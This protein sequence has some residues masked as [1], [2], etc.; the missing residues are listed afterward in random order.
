MSSINLMLCIAFS[1]C[2]IVSPAFAGEPTPEVRKI[3][4]AKTQAY[5]DALLKC[6]ATAMAKL[7]SPEVVYTS[8]AA[9]VADRA[10]VLKDVSAPK[11]PLGVAELKVNTMRQYGDTVVAN[12]DANFQH[13]DGQV[14]PH[15]TVTI[16][17]VKQGHDWLMVARQATG[18]NHH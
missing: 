4:L 6:D 7:L 17:W 15:G 12:Y 9:T 18:K 5:L 1:V 13:K 14:I 8:A 3:V 2:T 10:A 11:S 16:V